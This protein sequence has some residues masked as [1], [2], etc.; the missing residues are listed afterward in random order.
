MSA[1]SYE[2]AWLDYEVANKK[3]NEAYRRQMARLHLAYTDRIAR[4]VHRAVLEVAR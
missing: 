1:R 3:A 4:D 2:S